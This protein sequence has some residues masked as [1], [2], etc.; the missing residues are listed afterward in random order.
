MEIR[1]IK[2]SSKRQITLPR[3]F[4]AFRKGGRAII[5][6]RGSELVIR[7]VLANEAAL[8]SEKAL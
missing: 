1:T 8:L 7:P 3:V 6:S 5:M 4:S 2:I